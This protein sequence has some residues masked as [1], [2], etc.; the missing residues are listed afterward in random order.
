MMQTKLSVWVTFHEVLKAEHTYSVSEYF[1]RSSKS[2][3]APEIVLVSVIC[4]AAR[5][6][7]DACYSSYPQKP[8]GC[9]QYVLP[10]KTMLKSVIGAAFLL[11]DWTLQ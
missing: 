5:N 6:E 8:C 9:L 1:K 7:T 11:W 4:A 2:V 10:W 3:P